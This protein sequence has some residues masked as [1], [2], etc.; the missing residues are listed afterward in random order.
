[1][2]GFKSSYNGTRTKER[3]NRPAS[4]DN[5]MFTFFGQ[6]RREPEFMFEDLEFNVDAELALDFAKA[7]A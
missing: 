5:F 6:Y 7:T 3:K 1:M 2:R 4:K